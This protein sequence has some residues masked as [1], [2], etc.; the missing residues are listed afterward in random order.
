MTVY[1]LDWLRGAQSYEYVLQNA[2][3]IS[4]AKYQS[5]LAAQPCRVEAGPGN[6]HNACRLSSWLAYCQRTQCDFHGR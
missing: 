4:H 1:L 5:N 6:V 2:N 3:F